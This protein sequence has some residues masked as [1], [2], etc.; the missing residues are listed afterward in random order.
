MTPPPA[1]PCDADWWRAFFESPHSLRLA[2]FPGRSVTAQ[3]VRGLD[4]LMRPWEPR[5]VLDLCCGHG[6]HLIPLA[7]RGY[8]MVGLDASSLMVKRARLAARKGGVP[9][10]LVQGE[11]QHLPFRAGAFDVVLCLFNSFGYLPTDEEDEQV[12]RAVSRSLRPG[13][14]FLLDTRNRSYQ[15]SQLPFSEIVPLQRGGAVWLQCRTDA[16]RR[17][18]VSEFRCA[19]TGKLLH[20]ASIR[21]YALGELEEM[22][23][24]ADLHVEATFGGYDWGPFRG[25]SRELLIL[26]RR[27]TEAPDEGP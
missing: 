12:L 9:A 8:E 26:A 14:R 23:A 25:D 22:L 21:S 20:R 18:L 24:R 13:G 19:A 10:R 2:F 5:R 17:R 7:R 3:Q 15:L 27:G 11:A 4:R 6:R 16:A 1:A